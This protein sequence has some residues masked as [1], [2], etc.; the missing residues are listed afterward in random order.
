MWRWVSFLLA[1]CLAGGLACSIL[2]SR[3]RFCFL[4]GRPLHAKTYYEIDLR[5]GQ[6]AENNFLFEVEIRR[7]NRETEAAARLIRSYLFNAT[8]TVHI[9]DLRHTNM[10][11]FLY[12]IRQ[13]A[14]MLQ[15]RI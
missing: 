13:R 6:I 5:D 4:C 11:I 2:D 15:K 14:R 10:L 3:D 9:T 8:S 1:L 12:H 7:L